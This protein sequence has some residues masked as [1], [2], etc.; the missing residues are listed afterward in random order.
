MAKAD[1]MRF[2]D[3]VDKNKALREKVAKLT[4]VRDLAKE[5]NFKFTNL[6]LR[7]ALESKWGK[8]KHREKEDDPFTCCCFSETPGY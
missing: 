3:A 5:H 6:E 7:R 4:H 8:P 1:A 2:L